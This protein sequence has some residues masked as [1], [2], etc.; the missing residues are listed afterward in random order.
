MRLIGLLIVYV[1]L[2]WLLGFWPFEKGFFTGPTSEC[3]YD[4]GYDDGYDGAAPK[5]PCEHNVDNKEA[6]KSHSLLACHNDRLYVEP[7][8]PGFGRGFLLGWHRH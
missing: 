8:S 1:V 4:A 5:Q 2:A 3:S 6:D 7:A